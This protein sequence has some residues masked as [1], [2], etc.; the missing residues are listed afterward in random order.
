[1]ASS[2]IAHA[3]SPDRMESDLEA[4]PV[5]PLDQR[6]ERLRADLREDRS[7]GR[8]VVRLAHRG[9]ARSQRAVEESLQRRAAQIV[10]VG[11]QV[12]AHLLRV[13][14]RSSSG[15]H[16]LILRRET[17]FLAQ[18]AIDAHRLARREIRDGGDP[19]TPQLA[20]RGADGG[21]VLGGP[22]LRNDA[23]D[24]RDGGLLEDP[25]RSAR[26]VA[27]DLASGA[28]PSSRVRSPPRPSPRC[29]P[30]PCARPPPEERR[31]SAAASSRSAS[32]GHSPPGK[33]G[34][35]PS[36]PLE[37]R[38]GLERARALRD[39]LAHLVE[40]AHAREVEPHLR[41]P[42]REQVRV[43]VVEARPT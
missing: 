21:M 41:E 9:G 43:R 10:I 26:R 38:S 17:A 36:P 27:H 31:A 20:E 11:A 39:P 1:M 28:G 18:L 22:G 15:A 12:L 42:S 33:E 23:L 16:S 4:G 24:E 7:P 3:R 19:M 14:E 40:R 35:V 25:R 6:V 5:R 8:I 2:A 13:L 29:S 30:R 34:L 32:G 37:P